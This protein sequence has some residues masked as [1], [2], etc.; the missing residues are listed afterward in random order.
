MKENLYLRKTVPFSTIRYNR[1]IKNLPF[2]LSCATAAGN[3][4]EIA[5]GVA[6]TPGILISTPC[7]ELVETSGGGCD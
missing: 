2:W 3:V 7:R 6:P 5:T 4:V 1:E